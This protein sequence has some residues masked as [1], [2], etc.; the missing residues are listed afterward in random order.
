[1]MQAYFVTA[2][3]GAGENVLSVRF[4][5]CVQDPGSR[6]LLQ[7]FDAASFFDQI[8]SAL[9]NAWEGFMSA[10]ELENESRNSSS[11][12]MEPLPPSPPAFSAEQGTESSKM[13]ASPPTTPSSPSNPSDDQL[14]NAG[15]KEGGADNE[16]DAENEGGAG[17]E[18]GGAENKDNTQKN[19]GACTLSEGYIERKEHSMMLM[20]RH[21]ARIEI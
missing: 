1:M 21:S 18:E 20:L 2:L 13:D 8:Q 19:G 14:Q 7:E 12:S 3:P 10:F 4:C 5:H 11:S 6:N 15:S 16:N 9:Q 17:N